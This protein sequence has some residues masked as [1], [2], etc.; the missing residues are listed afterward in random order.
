[1]DL[2]LRA[3]TRAVAV[4]CIG[5][6]A[7]SCGGGGM[8]PPTPVGQAP[9]IA[10]FAASPSW[11]TTG[12]TATL[13]W[14]VTGA[15]SLTIDPIGTVSGTSTQIWATA[16]TNYVLTATNQYGSTKAQTKLA[17]FPPPTTWFAPIGATTAIPQ[18]QGATDYFDLFS[19]SAPWS[20]AANHVTVFKMYAGMLDLD[21][22]TL[23]TMFADLK[24][25]HIA[26]AIEW[27]PLDEPNRCGIGEGFDGTLGLHYA[28]RIQALG[29]SL[30][31]VAFDEPYDGAA[32]YDG[33]NACHWTPLQTA[34]NAAKNL[35]QLQ[36]AFPDA[37][38]GDIEVLP[39]GAALENWLE[40]YQQWV[41]AWQT[42]TGKPLAFFHFDVDWSSDW[43]PAAAALTR[44]LAARKIPVG[45]IYNGDDGASDATWI[46]LGE[47]HM[48]DFESHAA[49][50]PDE[51][52][53]QSWE[54][55]PKHLLPE[56]DPTSFTYLINR[57]FRERTTLMLS[58]T[59]ATAQGTLT[60]A[61]GPLDMAALALTAVPMSGTAQPSV[62]TQS[63][64]M[65][66]GAQYI[67]FGA[68]VGLENCSAVAL[69]AEFYL[70][71]FTLDAGAAGQ[72]HADFTNQLGGWGIWGNPLVGQVEGTSLHIQV[73]PGETMGLNS[74]SLPLL[75]AGAAY[76]LTVNAT[77]P[78]GSRGDGCAIAVFQDASFTELGRAVIQIVPLPIPLGSPQTDT[79]GAFAFALAPQTA[80]FNL[81]ADYTGSETLWP[82]AASVAINAPPALAVTGSLPG[83]VVG[84][85]YSGQFGASGG[86]TPYLW[87]G[88]TM[89]PG[90][91]LHQ[92]GS[93]TGTPTMAGTYTL[94]V[95]VADDSA[96]TQL[97]DTS[98][99][100]LIKG[101][102]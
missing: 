62:Y 84:L 68:R 55:Y 9:V 14:S 48:T 102:Q 99:Q 60:A 75:A 72:V 90:L 41:D 65:P 39:N 92:N 66:A 61:S 21:D 22:T 43:K 57:Y 69:P 4:I 29:G 82:A 76:T 51:A 95:S 32:L 80:S 70:T 73:T 100:I 98:L 83:G 23:R 71:D 64:K 1:M 59:A 77:I 101:S 81:W 40:G 94:S 30:Q 2:L 33:T 88:G 35:A 79:N 37:L 19:P 78:A 58:S 17:V 44:A 31:Y 20:A 53:F 5:L 36:S 15:T 38:A 11:M 85:A 34:Q 96:P 52:I 27:G 63:G 54:A 91:V 50:I 67:V 12:Q 93:L 6:G 89:P 25:R 7:T 46:A 16:D 13:N 86:R 24:R 49:L 97:A 10:S 56:T 45:H 26:F 87:V 47:E 28:Q 74:G 42:V 18:V 3:V 8:S